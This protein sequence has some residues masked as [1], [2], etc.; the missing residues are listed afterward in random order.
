MVLKKAGGNLGF[1]ASKSKVI[2][3]TLDFRT[4]RM[5]PLNSGAWPQNCY[6]AVAFVDSHRSVALHK[7]TPSGSTSTMEPIGSN[8]EG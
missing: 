4:A 5:P 3:L 7:L 8:G 1:L 2:G 6:R